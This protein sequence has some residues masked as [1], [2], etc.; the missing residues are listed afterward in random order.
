MG[1]Q[2]QSF[3]DWP[4]LLEI[5]LLNS[6]LGIGVLFCEWATLYRFEC[7]IVPL[8]LGAILGG[9]K[10]E[11]VSCLFLREFSFLLFFGEI[12][13]GEIFYSG[14][15]GSLYDDHITNEPQWHSG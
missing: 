4:V 7:D 9:E 2:F 10:M 15:G 6:I 13:L 8:C 14:E 12:V 11:A 3:T 1:G 5:A